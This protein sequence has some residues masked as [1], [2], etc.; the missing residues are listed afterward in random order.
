VPLMFVWAFDG[1]CNGYTSKLAFH[2]SSTESLP[3]FLRLSYQSFLHY[4]PPIGGRIDYL[5]VSLSLLNAA[6]GVRCSRLTRRR[7][8]DPPLFQLQ[9]S[10]RVRSLSSLPEV[11]RESTVSPLGDLSEQRSEKAPSGRTWLPSCLYFLVLSSKRFGMFSREYVHL[12]GCFSMAG[13][14]IWD[15]HQFPPPLP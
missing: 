12:L 5:S 2:S 15:Y 4:D 1:A 13:E 10:F 7:R 14:T 8:N 11:F 3:S 6:F 9:P